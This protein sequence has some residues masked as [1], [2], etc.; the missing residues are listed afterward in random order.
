MKRWI[1]FTDLDG[2]LLDAQNYSFKAA[3]KAL[4][5]LKQSG[6]PIIPCTSKTYLEVL[7]IRKQIQINDPFIVEN[8]SAVFFEKNFFTGYLI[9]TVSLQ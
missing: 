9:V 7:K 3:E 2:T 1:V 4:H 5:F 8:G 6:I